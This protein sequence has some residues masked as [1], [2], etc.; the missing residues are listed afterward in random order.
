MACGKTFGTSRGPL[1]HWLGR[2]TADR[3]LAIVADYCNGL[4]VRMIATRHDVALSTVCRCLDRAGR[5]GEE[6]EQLLVEDSGLPPQT[7]ARFRWMVEM[8]LQRLG[9]R[10]QPRN[11]G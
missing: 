7:A 3:L 6:L 5:N 1:L 9:H 4:P 2:R 10:G 11:G 8:R